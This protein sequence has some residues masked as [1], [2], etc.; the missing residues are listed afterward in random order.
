M[1]IEFVFK[2]NIAQIILTPDSAS[3]RSKLALFA[4]GQKYAK[5]SAPAN[6]PEALIIE[7]VAEKEN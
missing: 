2:G 6:M 4:A 1:Q 5:L 3:D 7:S